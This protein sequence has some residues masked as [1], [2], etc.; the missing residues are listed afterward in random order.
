VG[1]VSPAR[2]ARRTA[3]DRMALALDLLR[4]P[5]FDALVT[6]QSPFQEL[7]DVMA[8]LASGSLAALCHTISY[9]EG[10]T[11]TG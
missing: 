7:P 2:S 11:C 6:E 1:T 10:S 9:G 5:A 3:G 8:R 4:D